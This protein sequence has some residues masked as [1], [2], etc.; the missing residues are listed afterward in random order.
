[1]PAD[2]ATQRLRTEFLFWDHPFWA[3]PFLQPSPADVGPTL[4]LVGARGSKHL[5]GLLHFGDQCAYCIQ[6]ITHGI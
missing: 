2:R 6:L 3:K 5:A 1:M 4:N